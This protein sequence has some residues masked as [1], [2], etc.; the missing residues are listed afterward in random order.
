MICKIINSEEYGILN[1]ECLSTPAEKM[2][3]G[4]SPWGVPSYLQEERPRRFETREKYPELGAK[5]G[6]QS[7]MPNVYRSD[8]V[9]GRKKILY[10]E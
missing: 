2:K 7:I 8:V 3:L 5:E 6:K 1:L 9:G 10:L 4:T